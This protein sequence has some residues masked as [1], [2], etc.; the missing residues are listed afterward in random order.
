MPHASTEPRPRSWEERHTA[1]ETLS[2]SSVRALRQFLHA[3][4]EGWVLETRL[5]AAAR[6]AADA[7]QRGLAAERMLVAIKGAWSALEEVHRLP[8]LEAGEL[9]SR[10]VALSI[11]A[12]FAAGPV[13]GTRDSRARADARAAA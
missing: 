3:Y 1:G 8:L 11:R 5:A 2:R 13:P 6:M 4:R 12:Y 7:R 9:L 10:L